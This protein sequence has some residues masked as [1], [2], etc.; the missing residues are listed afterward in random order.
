MGGDNNI[1]DENGAWS[2]P[3]EALDWYRSEVKRLRA[4]IENS[5]TSQSI[6]I[7]P[8]WYY[9]SIGDKCGCVEMSQ[10]GL[11]I[12]DE[13]KV[14]RLLVDEDQGEF[15]EVIQQALVTFYET[16]KAPSDLKFTPVPRI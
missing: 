11:W 4:I 3:A 5:N 13:P 2:D 14:S 8:G 6:P 7:L 16:G 12:N 15:V 1:L 10:Q 9:V